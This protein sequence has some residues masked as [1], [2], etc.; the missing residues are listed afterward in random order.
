MAMPRKIKV[1]F[2]DVFP[3]GT[4]AVSEVT[5]VRDFDKSTKDRAIQAVDDETGLLV[6][7][8]DV[9]DGDPE[10]RKAQRQVTVKVLAQVQPVL[11]ENKTGLPFT[12]VEFDGMTAT[13]YIS[14]NGP[15]PVLAWSF[16]ATSVTGTKARERNS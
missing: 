10:A 7:A 8:V 6:W 15:R 12:P 2:Q 1:G 16:R 3:F 4:Y 14:D 5:P 11:P 13:P 9:M